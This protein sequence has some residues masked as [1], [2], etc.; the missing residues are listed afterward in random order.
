MY[1]G[2][3]THAQ[4]TFRDE[5]LCR[6]TKTLSTKVMKAVCHWHHNC[7]STEYKYNARG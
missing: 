6:R 5:N 3:D 7:L 4:H 2:Q 1:I